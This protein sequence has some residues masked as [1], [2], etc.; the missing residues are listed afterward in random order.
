MLRKTEKKT[1]DIILVQTPPCAFPLVSDHRFYCYWQ[2]EESLVQSRTFSKN[3]NMG[4]P[5]SNVPG[6]LIRASFDMVATTMPIPSDTI[7][8]RTGSRGLQTKS[9][10]PTSGSPFL[11]M[12]KRVFES[13]F[14][15]IGTGDCGSAKGDQ[16]IYVHRRVRR[17]TFL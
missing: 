10:I 4:K 5:S 1:Q 15:F 8:D 17:T 6:K 14:E 7:L 11:D 3:I 12:R 9:T 13:G 2:T 16:R